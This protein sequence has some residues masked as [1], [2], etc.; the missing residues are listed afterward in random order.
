MQPN[1]ANF[2]ATYDLEE[3]LLEDN[4]LRAR[5]RKVQD[6]EGLSTEMR[7]LEEQYVVLAFQRSIYL[8]ISR[9]TPYDYQKMHRRT[10]YPQNQITSSITAASTASRPATP[11]HARPSGAYRP[12]AP[13]PSP[14]VTS[15]SPQPGAY[16]P[17]DNGSAHVRPSYDER[18]RPSADGSMM[19]PSG[20][21]AA[22]GRKPSGDRVER[23][24]GMAYM[25]APTPSRQQGQ[26]QQQQWQQQ[27][28]PY[29]W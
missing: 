12:D 25:R 22:S 16:P 15:P 14:Y 23:D 24:D 8:T 17:H 1:K 3:L 7:Q 26:Q 19:R 5:E 29:H 11:D 21:S 6:I 18:L 20:E 28:Q 4:P 13:S 9:F 2:D 10:Y 27:Q